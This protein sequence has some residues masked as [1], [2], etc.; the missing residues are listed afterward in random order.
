MWHKKVWFVC[1]RK[2]FYCSS[3]PKSSIDQKNWANIKMS[4][5]EQVYFEQFQIKIMRIDMVIA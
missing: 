4:A 1:D 2:M 5:Y 3:T